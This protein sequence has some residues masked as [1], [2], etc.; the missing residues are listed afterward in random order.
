MVW[1]RPYRRHEGEGRL[2]ARPTLLGG[3]WK[4][5]KM[6]SAESQRA[7]INPANGEVRQPRKHPLIS[8]VHGN[9]GGP[10][11]AKVMLQGDFGSLNL[12]L[13]GHAAQ[14]PI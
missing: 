13:L 5:K 6:P 8:T 7:S 14:L 10:A 2:I 9:D 11:Q 3:E 4:N 1:P 12:A